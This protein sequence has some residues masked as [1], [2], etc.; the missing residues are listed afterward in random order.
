VIE[1]T[2]ARWLLLVPDSQEALVGEIPSS[3]SANHQV[4]VVR[5]RQR[6][7]VNMTSWFIQHAIALGILLREAAEFLEGRL[8]PEPSAVATEGDTRNLLGDWLTF[9]HQLLGS[10]D[11]KVDPT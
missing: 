11:E 2:D 4:S 7:L 10:T 1:T 5:T 6:L 9:V 8:L 3:D